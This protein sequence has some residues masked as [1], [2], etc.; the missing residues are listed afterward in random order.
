MESDLI[1][2]RLKD[3]AAKPQIKVV[4][5]FDKSEVSKYVQNNVSSDYSISS[6]FDDVFNA[7]VENKKGYYIMQKRVVVP[8][9]ANDLNTLEKVQLL[10]N[11]FSLIFSQDDIEKIAQCTFDVDKLGQFQK[12]VLTSTLIHYQKLIDNENVYTTQD[13]KELF[14]KV[15]VKAL[16]RND[17]RFS[18]SLSIPV[19]KDK[20]ITLINDHYSVNQTIKTDKVIDSYSS[21]KDACGLNNY[22]YKSLLF[23]Y[24]DKN[25]VTQTELILESLKS[26]PEKLTIND[27]K[28]ISQMI[29]Y[30]NVS[31]INY[32]FG[33]LYNV[34]SRD[35]QGYFQDLINIYQANQMHMKLLKFLAIAELHRTGKSNEM[36]RQNNNFIRCI[37]YYINHVS[38]DFIRECVPK[39]NKLV[40]DAPSWSYD[41]P[42]DEDL[43]TVEKLLSDFW[44]LFTE[45]VP[46]IPGSV[47]LLL[48]CV[49]QNSEFL[50]R[51]Q[52]L[53]NRACFAIFLLRF[54][55][56]HMSDPLTTNL[57][58]NDLAKVLQ[59]TKLFA[60][61]GQMSL[62]KLEQK[63]DRLKYNPI[64]EGSFKDGERFYDTLTQKVEL[65]SN[66]ISDDEL[67]QSVDNVRKF[68]LQQRSEDVLLSYA[69]NT[70][71]LFNNFAVD[72]LFEY[73]YSVQ[74]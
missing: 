50:F 72:G 52:S 26:F 5:P 20:V 25:W 24:F 22:A 70:K 37:L 27:A 17:S 68:L 19:S 28:A 30:E 29:S 7:H 21:A 42:T 47:R 45:C 73:L 8:P 31:F 10:K 41:N 65:E 62:I 35:I 44:A 6:L 59:F 43:K 51:T 13:E 53:N 54:L 71:N 66:P 1:I 16:C 3:F 4:P 61:A 63:T 46:K 2:N 67:I 32:Y 36:F 14:T 56:I 69:T 15:I 40:V 11:I 39:L 60:F 57:K 55:F 49:R 48:R 74:L 23:N 34:Q 58:P 9:K 18:H 12:Y 38:N 33:T 64:L